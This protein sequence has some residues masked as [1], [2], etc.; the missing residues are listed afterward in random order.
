[1]EVGM[2]EW[3]TI[4]LGEIANIKGGKRLPKEKQLSEKSTNHPYI[5]TRDLEYNKISI[6]E[7][8]FVPDEVFPAIKRYIVEKNDIIISIVGTIGLIA[9]IPESLHLASLTENCA[10]IV[11]IDS[12]LLNKRF[13]FYYLISDV[14]QDEIFKRNV[15][16]TQP[17]LPLYNIKTIPIPLPIIQEQKAIAEVLS[18]LDDKI[19][20]LYR[21][22]KTLEHM[23]ETHFRQWFLEEAKADWEDGVLGDLVEVKYGK[24]H[25][26]LLDGS[27]PVYGSGGIMRYAEKALFGD[28]SVLIPRKGTLNNVTYINE[29]FWTVDTM[30][31][32]IMKRPNLAKF[33]YH[34]VKEK[35]LAS[36]NVG[37]AVPSMTTQVLNNMPL[38]IPFD[39][40]LEKFENTVTPFYQKIKTNKNQINTLE[41][42]RDTLLPKLMSGEVTVKM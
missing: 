27:I 7:L 12:S 41:K 13:L 4:E 31:Y 19:D 33:I 9:I 23:A 22:N 32:T 29:P 10:K 30:F 2:S 15:G 34:F 1:M 35:D 14:G 25:K 20:L 39:E 28:E 16:S 8:L 24:D 6:S 36:M 37:S 21:Q 42:M 26:K 40:D 5:R 11:D 38:Q 18:S 17:K 3:K